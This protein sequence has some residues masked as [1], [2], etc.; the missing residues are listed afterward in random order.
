[1][2]ASELIKQL[3][4]YIEERDDFDVMLFVPMGYDGGHCDIIEVNFTN[5]HVELY[6]TTT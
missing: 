5:D 1:M 3:E 2:K 6:G 4:K